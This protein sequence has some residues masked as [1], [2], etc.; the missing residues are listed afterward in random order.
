MLT[1]DP[2]RVALRK[3]ISEA[4]GLFFAIDAQAGDQLSIRFGLTSQPDERSF[5]DE[6]L[7]YM[8]SARGT[9]EVSDG[10]KAFTGIL[11][12]VSAG[13]PEI[14]I[15]DEPEAFLHPSLASKLGSELAKGA[16][17]EEKYILAAT[18]SAQFVM[19]A[20]LSGAKVN[21]IQLTYSQNLGTARLLSSTDLTRLMQDPLLRS[22][23][24]ISALFY[25]YVIIGEADADRAQ[26]S[27]CLRRAIRG[28]SPTP[29]S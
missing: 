23:V 29:S 24:M 19:G 9:N 10:V 4:L 13:D 20:F 8:R 15:V 12:Q 16:V 26:M 5:N 21:I 7:N 27:A 18:H 6:A 25:D 1:D 11:L 3:T 14:I 2:K 28:G 17:A 22:V